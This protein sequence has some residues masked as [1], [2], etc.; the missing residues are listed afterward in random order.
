[1]SDTFM[2]PQPTDTD[3]QGGP[4]TFSLEIR[5][6]RTG[7][8]RRP[9]LGDRFLIGSDAVCDLRLDGRLAAPLHCLLRRDGDHLETERLSGSPI[10]INGLPAEHADLVEGDTLGVGPVR[11]IV[12]AHSVRFDIVR[13]TD[14]LDAVRCGD[15]DLSGSAASQLVA[16]IEEEEERV[17]DFD[18]RRKAGAAALLDATR[19]TRHPAA[20]AFVEVPSSRLGA[21]VARLV[22]LTETIERRETRRPA[23]ESEVREAAATLFGAQCELLDQADRLLRLAR[24]LTEASSPHRRAA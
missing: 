10:L 22:R 15:S 2:V 17:R 24:G 6:G 21:V 18:D 8:R 19:R 3:G 14:D 1:M 16:L 9:I 5:G 12:H 13:P 23:S 4:R 11:L 20:G 7:F